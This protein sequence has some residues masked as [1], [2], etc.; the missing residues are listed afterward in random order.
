[1][2]FNLPSWSLVGWFARAVA[3][4]CLTAGC[5]TD[6]WRA[7]ADACVGCDAS[8]ADVDDGNLPGSCVGSPLGALSISH[9][10]FGCALRCDG[11]VW[12]WG[13]NSNGQLGD[14]TTEARATPV[15]VR[16]LGG[17]ATA[18][19][20]GYT[21][22]CAVV[23]GALR[24]WGG[25]VFG[26][27][28]DGTRE[29]RAHPVSVVGLDGPV[30]GVTAGELHTCALLEGGALR[31]WGRNQ[32]GGLGDGTTMDRLTPRAVLALAGPISTVVAGQYGNCALGTNG[33]VRCWGLNQYGAIGD[34]TT[35]NRN[36]PFSVVLP[37]P[38]RAVAAMAN[39]VC[40][41]LETGEVWCWG[42]N[43]DG[44]LGDRTLLTRTLPVAVRGLGVPAVAVAVGG[45]HT[46]AA[47]AEGAL[48]CWGANERGQLG[49]GT[50]TRHLAPTEILGLGGAAVLVAAGEST[51]CVALPDGRVRCWGANEEGQLGDGS[52]I[53]SS[54]P[55]TTL[56]PP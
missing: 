36:V 18:I 35:T 40:A 22:A 33:V 41:A 14:G 38:A 34:G 30:V 53:D 51:T 39:H 46:C 56:L 5:V 48:R 16:A 10:H 17:P 3:L 27:L 20:T 2:R 11:S 13:A 23:R 19:A 55:V 21:H 31:C 32:F 52:N 54:E 47:T 6:N 24:C 7:P 42:I 25:N 37:G 49:D 50:A 45:R 28:G 15:A 4:P 12:C 29:D 8:T 44:A 26:A 43:S 1:M 9:R